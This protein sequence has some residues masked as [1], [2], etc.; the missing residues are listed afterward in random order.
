MKMK[1]EIN[2]IERPWVNT[3][4]PTLDLKN[5]KESLF[6]ISQEVAKVL[7][8]TDTQTIQLV[9]TGQNKEYIITLY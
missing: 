3:S 9:L 7:G 4:L 8:F 5:Q 2:T 1:L 6:E